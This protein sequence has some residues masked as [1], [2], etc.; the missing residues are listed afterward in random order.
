MHILVSHWRIHLAVIENLTG[1]ITT[2]EGN[3]VMRWCVN[4][5]A[6]AIFNALSVYLVSKYIPFANI[7][8]C[9]TYGAAAMVGRHSGFTP[10]LRA[11]APQIITIHCALYSGQ[12][13][14]SRPWWSRA[15]DRSSGK[16]NKGKA[17]MQPNFPTFVCWRGEKFRQF[18]PLHPNSLA[19]QRKL[20]EKVRKSVWQCMR[21]HKG[22][23]TVCVSSNC[24]H[25]NS[26]FLHGRYICI[27]KQAECVS[28]RN[29]N[30][31]FRL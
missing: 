25:E 4:A 1:D 18:T 8:G 15:S 6:E 21:I 14:T 17:E 11:M 26:D 22:I 7:I 12:T 3:S 29:S 10:R 9:T 24:G 31:T 23:P 13:L 20:P 28:T 2:A 5:T 19:V 30:Y 16:P 27:A